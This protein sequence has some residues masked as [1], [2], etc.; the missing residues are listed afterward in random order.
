[1]KLSDFMLCIVG[2]SGKLSDFMS[3]LVG[4]SG[5]AV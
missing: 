2:L 1:M 3:C 4:L 5:E